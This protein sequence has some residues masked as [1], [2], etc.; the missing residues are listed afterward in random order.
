MPKVYIIKPVNDSRMPKAAWLAGQIANRSYAHGGTL[1]HEDISNLSSGDVIIFGDTYDVISQR[2]GNIPAGVMAIAMPSILS[3]EQAQDAAEKELTVFLT[4][5]RAQE[6]AQYVEAGT[7]VPIYYIPAEPVRGSLAKLKE[8]APE[9]ADSIEA[10]FSWDEAVN[11]VYPCGHYTKDNRDGGKEPLSFEDVVELVDY[12]KTLS[13]PTVIVCGGRVDT[14]VVVSLRQNC[15]DDVVILS[16]NE[17]GYSE[18]GVDLM[19][20]VTEMAE[21]TN[22]PVIAHIDALAGNTWAALDG[23]RTQIREKHS[24]FASNMLLSPAKRMPQAFEITRLHKADDFICFG[25]DEEIMAHE[26]VEKSEPTGEDIIAVLDQKFGKPRGFK[27][28]TP[29]I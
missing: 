19:S 29:G 20:V 27:P 12:V 7:V 16:Q 22:T 1:A 4:G 26:P 5:T 3:A 10:L 11:V 21:V 28:E 9:T 17:N 2:A 18:A 13:Y 15:Y 6:L 23:S 24:L 8:L 14:D 25:A